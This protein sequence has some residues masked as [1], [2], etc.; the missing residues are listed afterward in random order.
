MV[1]LSRKDQKSRGR[2]FDENEE[3][4]KAVQEKNFKYDGK[5]FFGDKTAGYYCRPSCGKYT[6][7]KELIRNKDNFGWFENEKEAKS[8]QYRPCGR[9]CKTKSPKLRHLIIKKIYLEF[10]E[11][12]KRWPKWTIITKNL[13]EYAISGTKFHLCREFQGREGMSL[14]TWAKK[15]LGE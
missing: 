15:V 1:K 14:K 8:Y 4:F 12:N 10:Y 9:C 7:I 5:F 2:G 13:K 3:Y 6:D 11:K